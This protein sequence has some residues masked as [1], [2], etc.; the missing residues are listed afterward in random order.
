M[1]NQEKQEIYMINSG[2]P[3]LMRCRWVCVA[4]M[5]RCKEWLAVKCHKK[6]GSRKCYLSVFCDGALSRLEGRSWLVE[7]EGVDRLPSA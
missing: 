7:T 3:D 4:L 5:K 2:L 1:V 6:N